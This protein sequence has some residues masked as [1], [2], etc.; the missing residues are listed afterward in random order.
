MATK[1]KA[2]KKTAPG[3]DSTAAAVIAIA[4]A[5]GDQLIAAT[6]AWTEIRSIAQGEL[7]RLAGK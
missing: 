5:V 4:K 3:P 1:K 2:K 6:R 7:N